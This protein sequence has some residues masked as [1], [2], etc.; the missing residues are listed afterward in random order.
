ALIPPPR[1]PPPCPESA[2]TGP[3][4]GRP[5]R[6]SPAECAPGARA[7]IPRHRCAGRRARPRCT[8]SPGG[9]RTSAARSSV[10]PRLRHHPRV[11]RRELRL[12]VPPRRHGEGREILRPPPHPVHPAHHLAAVEVEPPRRHRRRRRLRLRV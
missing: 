11:E 9:S 10:P 1:A 3:N 8:R 2:G 4:T 12:P 5:P 6:S 7:R